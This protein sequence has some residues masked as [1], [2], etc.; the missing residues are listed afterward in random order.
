MF[1]RRM[2]WVMGVFWL[3]LGAH[4]AVAQEPGCAQDSECGADERCD[5]PLQLE[6]CVTPPCP[7]LGAGRCVHQTMGEA[8]ADDGDCGG[9]L[10]C[11][12]MLADPECE[13]GSPT[14]QDDG[15]CGD[16]ASASG[17]A[18]Q[19]P[20]SSSSEQPA[21]E[22]LPP[23]GLAGAAAPDPDD[24]ASGASS[25]GDGCSV[26]GSNAGLPGALLA[27]VLGLGLRR[28]ARRA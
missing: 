21:S 9:G 18:Q 22:G 5:L 2:W 23:Q 7:E 11:V 25:S 6:Q 1:N 20:V 27:L 16:L 4:S 8:C 10:S 15:F 26:T 19:A 24:A 28:R 3:A 13:P 14:C 17:P 12:R